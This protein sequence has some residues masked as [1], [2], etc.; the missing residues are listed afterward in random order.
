LSDDPQPAS[1]PAQEPEPD[2]PRGAPPNQRCVEHPDREAQLTCPRCKRHHCVPCFQ[3]ALGICDD[4]L[5][6]DPSAVAPPMPFEDRSRSLPAR[7]GATLVTALRPVKSA[8]AFATDNR[9]DALRFALWTAL[10][11]ALLSGIIPHTRT[12]LFAGSFEIRLLGNPD[13]LAVAL[14]VARAALIQVALTGAYLLS[15]LVPYQSLVQAT[16]GPAA[17]AHAF[18]VL[19]YR[20][21]LVPFGLMLLMVASYV[22]AAPPTDVDPGS[23]A[24][25]TLLALAY[26]LKLVTEVLLMLAMGFTARLACGLSVLW[27]I[28]AVI[29]PVA[30][31][32]FVTEAGSQLVQWLLPSPPQLR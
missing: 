7:L 26:T 27:A 25:P 15:L 9:R 2:A 21:W 20:I 23:A 17:A 32:F 22:S 4:C 12:L 5:R 30:V 6:R 1:E 13:G 31:S 11:L 3:L 28:A 29:V 16:A 10:P 8:P 19:M 24:P 14:D 18:R